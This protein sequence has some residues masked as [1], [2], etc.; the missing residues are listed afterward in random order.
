MNLIWPPEKTL[1]HNAVD[2]DERDGIVIRVIEGSR[3][4]GQHKELDK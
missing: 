4:R 1:L 2:P 3:K